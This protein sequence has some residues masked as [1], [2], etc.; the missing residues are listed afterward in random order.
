MQCL[1]IVLGISCFDSY[2]AQ[3]C[4][5]LY[6][7]RHLQ[8]HLPSPILFLQCNSV[9]LPRRRGFF[10]LPLKSGTVGLIAEVALGGFQGPVI[11]RDPAPELFTGTLAGVLSHTWLP[12]LLWNSTKQ[13]KEASWIHEKQARQ[14][15][16]LSC[17]HPQRSG[18]I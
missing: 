18:T 3:D 17:P 14:V 15:G 8:Q 9:T 16:H 13:R 11:K 2:S 6:F 4:G 7:Q 5:R 12:G 10:A 1:G